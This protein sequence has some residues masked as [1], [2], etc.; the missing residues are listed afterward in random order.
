MGALTQKATVRSLSN[1]KQPD[2]PE[3]WLER[4]AMLFCIPFAWASAGKGG[5]NFLRASEHAPGTA[6]WDQLAGDRQPEALR[7]RERD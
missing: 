1:R 2:N 3:L 6:L 7:S 5:S 4:G